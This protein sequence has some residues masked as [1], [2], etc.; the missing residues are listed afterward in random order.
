MFYPLERPVLLLV[1]TG[2]ALFALYLAAV[3]QG[4]LLAFAQG[5]VAFEKNLLH[6]LLHDARHVAGFPC[7]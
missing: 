2:A 6:E 7:H 5:R 1:A 4:H 3:D